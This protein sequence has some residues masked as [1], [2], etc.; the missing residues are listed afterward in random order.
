MTTTYN[1]RQTDERYTQYQYAAETR[2]IERELQTPWPQIDTVREVSFRR[3]TD[4][5]NNVVI[6]VIDGRGYI[7][8]RVRDAQA[9]IVEAAGY[10]MRA[11]WNYSPVL[12]LPE[13][14]VNGFLAVT[15]TMPVEVTT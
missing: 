8:T 14:F 13:A 15:E 6:D 9:A 12:P 7:T 11:G 4:D 3:D 1:K 2:S 5:P 10:A